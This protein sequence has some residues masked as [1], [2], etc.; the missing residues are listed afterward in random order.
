VGRT[1]RAGIRIRERLQDT[2]VGP[3]YR[4]EYPTGL[5]VAVVLLGARSEDSGAL[6]LLRQR[7]RDAIQIQHPN[8]AAIHELSETDDGLVYLV[9][10]HL[11]GELL[12]ETLARRRALPLEEA[13][14]ICLQVAA[15]LRAAHE[16]GWVHGRLSPDTILLTRTADCRPMVKLI[17]FAQGPLLRGIGTEASSG[18]GVS[19]GYASPERIAGHPPDVRSDV[20]SLG[21]VLHSLLTGAPPAFPV[22]GGPV[23]KSMRAV[24]VRALAP[25]PARRFQTVAEF[26]AAL[27]PTEEEEAVPVI[28][29]PPRAG[30]KSALALGAVAVLV[31]AAVGVWLLR[32]THWS[33]V[34]AGVQESG[35]VAV[36]VRDS[37]PASTRRPADTGRSA[38]GRRHTAPARTP[39][40]SAPRAPAK[41]ESRDSAPGPRLSPFLRSHPWV[42]VSGERFYYPSSCLVALRSRDLRYF[43]SEDE[44]RAGGFVPSPG[45]RCDAAEPADTSPPRS[46]P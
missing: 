32:S 20:Y 23:P 9:A 41:R 35:S 19:L 7:C 24:L 27:L 26:V 12:S 43:R 5:E 30:R 16:A 14:D 40:D 28:S 46:V 38:V 25:S 3:L 1:L 4:A 15:G 33:P 37:L 45:A 29:T 18:Q 31:A 34:G 17:G 6:A 13:L 39:H 42:A 22:E 11:T 10:E 44:A 2:P 21:A 36:V 8:V